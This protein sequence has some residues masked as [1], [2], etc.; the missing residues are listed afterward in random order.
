MKVRFTDKADKDYASLTVAVQNSSDLP[1]LLRRPGRCFVQM[2]QVNPFHR[3]RDK[4]NH[5]QRQRHRRPQNQRKSLGMR[6]AQSEHNQRLGRSPL[7]RA[8]IVKVT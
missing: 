3:H 2:A 1:P 5:Q 4:R 6:N 7:K 8:Q